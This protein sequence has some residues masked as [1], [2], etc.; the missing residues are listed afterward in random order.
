MKGG[1]TALPDNNSNAWHKV[2]LWCIPDYGF[3]LMLDMVWTINT[4]PANTSSPFRSKTPSHKS[5]K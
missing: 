2:W 5:A 4:D 3:G 1:A